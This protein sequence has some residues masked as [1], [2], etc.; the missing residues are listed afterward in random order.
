MKKIKVYAV[1]P[2]ERP[3]IEEWAKANAEAYELDLTTEELKPEN[4]ETAKGFDG[5]TTMQM[6]PIVQPVYSKLKEYGIRNIAQRSAGFDMY[7]LEAASANDII[8]TNVPSYSPE[9]IA[10]FTVYSALKIIR[11]I[12]LIESRVKDQN[13]TWEPEI[14]ARPIHGMTVAVIGVGRIGSRVCRLF[15]NGF[16]A[17]VVGYDIKPRKKFKEL[18][19]YKDNLEETIADADIVT[20]HMPLTEENMYQF[21]YDLFKKMKKGAVLVNTAR[22]KIVRTKDLIK[23]VDEGHI[24]GAALDVYENE[25]EYMPKD[26]RGRVIEDDL[27]VELLNHPTIIYTPH[28]AYYTDV[29][30]K[31]LAQGGLDST[32]EVIETGDS[33]NR[34]N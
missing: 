23:A 6:Y 22:G 16:G 17:H 3:Y 26:W 24:A 10:E 18:V 30:M 25:A 1:I 19:E 27:F 31:N 21:D 12:D 32:V 29:A 9:S 11:K 2:E 8:I 4:V 33:V 28:I 20:I 15:K 5:V 34:V 14:L 13:F 7:D